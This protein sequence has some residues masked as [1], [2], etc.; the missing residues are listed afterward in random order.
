MKAAVYNEKKE[1]EIKTTQS[2]LL[3]EK[4]A[5]IKVSG[6][7][8]C[9]SDIVKLNQSLVKKNTVLGH[10]VT[11]FIH[12]IDNHEVFKTGDR[13]ALGHHVPC[14]NCIYCK[15]QNFSMCRK[16]KESNI[17]P[18]GFCE[19]ISVSKQHLDYTVFKIP[20]K[21]TDAQASFTEPIACCLRAVKRSGINKGD[22]VLVSGLGSIGLIMGQVLK[23]YGAKVIGIDLLEDRLHIAK[24]LGFD[25]VYKHEDDNQTAGLIMENFQQEGADKVFLASGNIKSLNTALT[26]VRDGG[27]ILVFASVSSEGAGFANNDIYYRE[28]TLLGSYSPGPDDLKNSLKMIEKSII[29]VDNLLKIYKFNQINQAIF[30]TVNNKVIKAYIN[31]NN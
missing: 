21:L 10:E 27:T 1:L 7:G 11:G 23:H 12:K 3:P 31:I 15:N 9:G 20:E 4:G 14:F 22:I 29:K 8:L 6:C 5:I 13:V 17:Y 18:G 30:D 28:L 24:K 16:F 2:P 19:Y 25:A 26:S